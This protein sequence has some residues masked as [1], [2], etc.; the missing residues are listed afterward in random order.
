ME[1]KSNE[2][3]TMQQPISPASVETLKAQID[4]FKLQKHSL[5]AALNIYKYDEKNILE[6]LALKI[7]DGEKKVALI[8]SNI[9]ALELNIKEA[10]GTTTEKPN[11]IK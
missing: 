5:T 10:E 2:Q 1:E 6:V 7:A 9:E 3:K 11:K 4:E 8:D